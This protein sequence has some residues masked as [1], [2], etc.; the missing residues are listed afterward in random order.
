MTPPHSLA[1]LISLSGEGGVE[2]MVLNLVRA[3]AEMDLRIDLVLIR[4]E[5]RHLQ[6][7]HENVNVVRLGTRHSALSVAPLVRYLQE[8]RPTLLL[9]AKDR[10]GRAALKARRR[11]GV[12]TRVFIRLGTTLSEALEGRSGLRKWLRYRPMR[13]LYPLADGIVAVSRGVADDVRQITGLPE[14]RVHV[15]RNPVIT[16]GLE[17]LAAK[18]APHP[19]LEDGGD[20]VI[21]GMGRLTRQKDFPT[22]LRAF[23]DIQ[24]HRPARLIILGEGGDREALATLTRSMGMQDKVS[25]PGFAVNPYAWLSRS[26][27]FVLSSAWEG[28]PN[29]LTEA[30]ALGV[31]VVSTDCRSGPREILQDGRYGP[32]VP[33]GDVSALGKAILETLDTPLPSDD[34][35]AAV[36]EYHAETSARR[37]LEVMGL[38]VPE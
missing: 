22:L 32:L 8:H 35:R 23:A 14:D 19:W 21:I 3:L 9:A 25:M 5:S 29:A 36:S 27:L 16:P 38:D 13:Q 28:S 26:H 7:L 1:I 15:V 33:V 31:P 17:A 4:E 6:D 2:R 34:I 10:A 37:Y 12:D 18:P 24:V 30:M 11:A 20:P